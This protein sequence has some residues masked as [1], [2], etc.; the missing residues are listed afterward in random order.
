MISKTYTLYGEY[1]YVY[2]DIS[3]AR[4]QHIHTQTQN[5]RYYTR[6]HRGETPSPGDWGREATVLF[7]LSLPEKILGQHVSVLTS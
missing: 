4:C 6:H 5:E 3:V 1:S 2:V 7:M